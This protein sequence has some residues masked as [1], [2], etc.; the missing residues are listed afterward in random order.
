MAQYQPPAP[1]YGELADRL[2]IKMTRVMEL[3]LE[4]EEKIWT[5]DQEKLEG[6]AV[7]YKEGLKL[8]RE[9]FRMFYNKLV[10]SQGRLVVKHEG[11]GQ[12]VT[13]EDLAKMGIPVETLKQ[14][15]N[16][17]VVDGE[18]VSDE[19]EDAESKT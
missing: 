12:G 13:A 3:G 2:T 18:V 1:T 6:Y 9:S 16:M 19:V 15:A 5:M 17:R 4:L 11:G 10:P 14:L 8:K 7:K